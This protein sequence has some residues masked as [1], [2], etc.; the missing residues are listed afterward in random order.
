MAVATR[1]PL[2]G[3]RN[4]LDAFRTA[5][6]DPGCEGFCVYGP[7]GVGKTRLGDECLDVAKAAGRRVLRAT[8]DRSTEAVPF[9]AVAHLMPARALAGV[10]GD[11]F[12]PAIFAKLFDTARRALA[13]TA[14]ESGIPV[15][16]LDDAHV[17][18]AASLMLAD[19]LLEQRLMFGIVTVVTGKPVP[20]TVTKWWR[21]ER[22]VRIDLT[23]L[24]EIDVDTLLHIALEG[25]LDSAASSDLWRASRGNVLALRE[26]V[27]GARSQDVLVRRSDVWFL[28]GELLAS[29]RLRELI[30]ARIARLDV[31]ARDVVERLAL[32]QPLG[33]GQLEVAAGLA[34]LEDI[35][36]DGLI[37][38]RIDDRR[39][40]VRLA[41]PLHGDV[42]RAHISPLRRR[43]ILLAEAEM[44]EAHGA[45]RREDPIR[46]STWRLEATGRAD[47]GLLVLAACLARYDHKFRRA[48]DLAR[49][50][51]AAGP[52]P[53]AGLVLGEALYN[54][55]SF[56]EAERALA[57]AF[58]WAEDDEHIVR[59]ATVRR[60]N[61]FR[62]CR[63]DDEA[64]EVGQAAMSR[65]TSAAARDELRAGE[66]EL[67]AISGRPLEALELLDDIDTR[68]SRLSVLA[69][70]PRAVALATIGRT[71]EAI[72]VSEQAYLDHLA[73]GDELG[74][75]SPGTHRVNLLF[76]MIQAGR[77]DEADEKGRSWFEVA[78]RARTP[79]GVIWIG[80]HLG[81]CALNRGRPVTALDWTDRVCTAIDASGLEGLRP[82][83]LAV[84]GVAHAL[85][86]DVAASAASADRVEASTLGFGFVAPELPLA[87]AWAL[88]AAGAIPA[89]RD[90]LVTAA[91][92][93]ERLGH[94][95]AAAWLL[96]DAS[97]VGGFTTAAPRLE[98]LSAQCDS[99]LVAARSAHA[100]ALLTGDADHL[101]EV[102]DRFE[103]LG[104]RLL[105]AE[106]VAAAADLLRRRHEQRRAAA[107]DIRVNAL[108]ATCEGAIT[109]ALAGG[110]AVV[111]LTDREREIA[112]MAASGCSSRVIAD[113]LFLS[114]R[115]IDNHLGRIYAKLGVASRAALATALERAGSDR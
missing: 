59:I 41:H 102:A 44:V 54:L 37:A 62:G 58:E 53:A 46:I 36:R 23:E 75:A 84:Q 96:H 69:A 16:L 63:R 25:P 48:A 1:W 71:T 50:A 111:P 76:A 114:V 100:T 72:A 105:A 45:R 82:A 103:R 99:D 95:P 106:A 17:L 39:E 83:A 34:T 66:A 90:L 24:T 3:R 112:L 51:L 86:G 97:R 92:D 104:A 43:S 74:I 35:E 21:D 13:P 77:F 107:L 4:E 47:P 12:D 57:A 68:T 110:A 14:D 32:C 5:F 87:R 80:V 42:V 29:P 22:A 30:E 64:V 27:L 98:A 40:S 101:V 61:L 10:A 79:L 26:L 94:L 88:I 20:D 19:R 109:P 31:P 28:D 52:S 55:G 67:M 60:R 73:L 6:D 56:D 7:A 70:M 78:A 91:D 85:L 115:T 38:V 81:R 65:V 18:D 108:A 33:L 8:A 9:G 15:V 113:R 49:A 93:A 89:A 11:P 2:V